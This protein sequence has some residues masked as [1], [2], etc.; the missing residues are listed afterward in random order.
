VFGATNDLAAATALNISSNIPS[1]PAFVLV[2]IRTLVRK[3]RVQTVADY[4]DL[5]RNVREL[6]QITT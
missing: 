1:R 6:L 4:P 5:P 3:W 2:T